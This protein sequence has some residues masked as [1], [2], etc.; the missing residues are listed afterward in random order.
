MMTKTV[1]TKAIVFPYITRLR[2]GTR[3]LIRP[4]RLEDRADL[5]R[6]F[7]KLSLDSRRYRFLTPLRKLTE[8]Q[9]KSLIEVDNPNHVAIGVKDTGRWGKP[10]IGVA[11]FIRLDSEPRTAEFAITVIDAYQNRGLGT[12]LLEILMALARDRGVEVLRGFL[13]NDNLAVIRLL[14]RFG[15]HIKRESGNVLQADLAV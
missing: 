11:R 8:Y 5:V 1:G 6:G 12:L 15:A 14:E 7:E 2:D 10:G 13:L 3:I 9:L 4:L